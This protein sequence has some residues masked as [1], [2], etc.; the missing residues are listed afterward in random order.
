MSFQQIYFV[1]LGKGESVEFNQYNSWEIVVS[2][3]KS[4]IHDFLSEKNLDQ[5]NLIIKQVKL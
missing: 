3:A 1:V 2:L 4:I 5:S